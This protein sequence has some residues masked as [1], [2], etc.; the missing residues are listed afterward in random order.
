MF[1][2]VQQAAFGSL[3]STRSR[4]THLAEHGY[5][6]TSSPSDNMAVLSKQPL[7]TLQ[8]IH[9]IYT[10]YEAKD[11]GSQ[12]NYPG[13]PKKQQ[14]LRRGI[15]AECTLKIC[16]GRSKVQERINKEGASEVTEGSCMNTSS[17]SKRS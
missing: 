1:I 4:R 7:C 2:F 17:Q 8:H 3:T 11:P 5:R 13:K 9:Q 14:G 10:E 12:I 6:T 16:H 15:N